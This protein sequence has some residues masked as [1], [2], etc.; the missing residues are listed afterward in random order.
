MFFLLLAF[1]GVAPAALVE[2]YFV[3]VLYPSAIQRTVDDGANWYST[4]VGLFHFQRTGGDYQGFNVID[5]YGFC[6]EPREFVS[7]GSS[8]T[9][10]WNI[11]ENGA[12]NIGGMGAARAEQLRELY[13]RYFPVFTSDVDPTTAQALQIATW[14]IVR[15]TSNDLDVL[16]GT[17]RFRNADSPSALVLAQTFLSSLTGSGVALD[18]VFALTAVGAQDIVVQETPE[19]ATALLL[20]AGLLLLARFRRRNRP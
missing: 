12:T 18:N 7:P 1:P 16:N 20:G 15:E 5:F 6:I 17:T 9:Y 4:E 13:A 10:E 3:E 2:T 8:Y 19:P 11:L 14:E